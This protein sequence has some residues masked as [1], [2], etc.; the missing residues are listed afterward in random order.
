MLYQK[1]SLQIN[2]DT[3][4]V[5]H[6]SDGHLDTPLQMTGRD[7]YEAVKYS[8]KSD[9]IKEIHSSLA[10]A[11][12]QGSEINLGIVIGQVLCMLNQIKDGN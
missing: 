4:Y 10:K 6:F 1:Q 3:V 9:K 5:L 11:V 12:E 7:L 2:K 8:M